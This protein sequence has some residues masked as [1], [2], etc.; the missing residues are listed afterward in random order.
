LFVP[1]DDAIDGDPPEMSTDHS[2]TI[3]RSADAADAGAAR[4]EA[5]MRLLAFQHNTRHGGHGRLESHALRQWLAAR[6]LIAGPLVG[7]WEGEEWSELSEQDLQVMVDFLYA[8]F[9]PAEAAGTTCGREVCTA[10]SLQQVE[11]LAAKIS[12]S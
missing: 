8:L 5:Q 9:A 4:E 1:Y 3:F 12:E 10:C 2:W 7:P 11:G 6:G